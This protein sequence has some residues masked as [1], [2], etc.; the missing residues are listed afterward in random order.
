MREVAALL[1]VLF[2]S[3]GYEAA[4]Q[5][6]SHV[7]DVTHIDPGRQNYFVVDPD[8]WKV[9]RPD[10]ADLRLYDGQSQVP[11]ALRKQ[12]A[13]SSRQET[14][15]NVLNLGTVAGQAEFDLDVRRVTEYSRVRL[16]LDAKNFVGTAQIEGRQNPNHRSGTQLGSGTL[17]DFT[18]EGLGSN[19]TLKIPPSSFPYLH[20]R[21]AAGIRPEQ[22]KGAF[23]ASA[24]ESQPAWLRAGSCAAVSPPAKQ[25]VFECSI[26]QGMPIE[27]LAFEVESGAVN[28]SRT[29][30]LSDEQGEEVERGTISRVRMTR[31]GQTIRSEDLAI[32]FDPRTA[33]KIRVAIANGDDAPLPIRQLWALSVERR[34][35]F[36][37]AGR[38]T[39]RLDYGDPKLEAPSYDYA[40]L[41]RP[42]AEAAIAQLGVPQLNPQFTGRPDDRPWSERHKA[43]LWAAMLIAVALLAALAWRGWS[44]NKQGQ[45]A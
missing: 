31:A 9:A 23:I 39:L 7:R 35:Y 12:V 41:F 13:D 25:S 10:L 8:L 36:D 1:V 26:P 19:F 28:F 38:T 5:Y 17:Y 34:I 44:A 27:R 16:S 21:L 15:A 3:T 29:V 33:G 24:S 30:I 14:A 2:V 4:M 37:P 20:V 40:K 32:D 11:F 22:V 18:L 45:S 6:F 42:D 43:V